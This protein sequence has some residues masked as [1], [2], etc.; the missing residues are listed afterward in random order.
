MTEDFFIRHGIDEQKTFFPNEEEVWLKYSPAH[1]HSPY[2]LLRGPWN[3]S[4]STFTMRFNNAM[5]IPSGEGISEVLFKP[6]TGSGCGSYKKFINEY[7]V[8]QPL[9]S[10][11]MYADAQIHGYVHYTVG[12]AG[13]T[14]ALSVDAQL[15][16]QFG[17][18]DD[19]IT[20]LTVATAR[21]FKTWISR[22]GSPSP[23]DEVNPVVCF[24]YSPWDATT[25]TLLSNAAPGEPG[26]PSCN[27]ADHFLETQ[28]AADELMASFFV[29]YDPDVAAHARD[30]IAVMEWEDKKRVMDLIF[31]RMQIDGDMAGSGS[32][33]DPLFWVAHGAVERLF[34]RTMFENVL[35]DKEYR[36]SGMAG[37]EC[38]GHDPDQSNFWLTGYEFED[39]TVLAHKLTNREL[40]TILDPTGDKYATLIPFV[41]DSQDYDHC[42]G[43]DDWWS[44]GAMDDHAPSAS[45]LTAA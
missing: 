33:T 38:Q 13:G 31:S 21:F 8:N 6:F 25:H 16:S 43:F 11:L 15:R 22:F 37:S 40:N 44:G 28:E 5:Q 24:N 10:Y 7:V 9:Y 34:Q 32:A 35:S 17:F 30:V 3:F 1:V 19:D 45:V 27:V 2:G 39:K 12:G 14:K 41:Y 18:S 23:P 26:G 4:P 36:T 42:D 20:M 29:D